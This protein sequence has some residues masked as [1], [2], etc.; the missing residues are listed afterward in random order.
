MKEFLFLS[1]CV[2]MVVLTIT[3]SRLF[4]PF[5]DWVDNV[6]VR[7]TTPTHETSL[8]YILV[9]CP[10]CM[11]FWVAAV[12]SFAFWSEAGVVL[13]QDVGARLLTFF[14]MW[15]LSAAACSVLTILSRMAE[16]E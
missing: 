4:R 13:G 16:S 3:R 12:A 11:S 5:R 10:F 1:A 15:A 6:T 14:G 9:A 7:E 2:T 8:V